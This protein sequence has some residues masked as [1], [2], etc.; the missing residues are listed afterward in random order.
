[1]KAAVAER[2]NANAITTIT[3]TMFVP[4]VEWKIVLWAVRLTKLLI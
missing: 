2:S 3:K 4:P 1:M